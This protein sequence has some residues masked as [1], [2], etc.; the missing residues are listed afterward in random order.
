MGIATAV[1]GL[2]GA[3]ISAYGQY[4][5]GQATA[6]ADSYQAQVAANNA[7]I[8]QTQANL[9]TQKGEQ[10]VL[11]QGLKNRAQQGAIVAGMAANGVDVN[12]GSAADVKQS[13]DILGL[14]DEQTKMSN[15]NIEN[16]G[17]RSQGA[18]YTAQSQLDSAEAGWAKQSALF[19]AAGS[20]L[21]GASD[22]A[23]KFSDWSS[24]S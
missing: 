11:Q 2:V 23:G 4:E 21:G 19:G 9:A 18:A 10:D 7:T 8:A 5:Q 14:Q 16:Y 13:A 12:T 17:Y 6:K 1:I 3:G 15:A 24:A 22:F 20:L